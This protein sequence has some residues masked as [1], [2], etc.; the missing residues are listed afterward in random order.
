MSNDVV[1]GPDNGEIGS[2]RTDG[3]LNHPIRILVADDQAL[4][5]SGFA[6]MLRQYADLV[7]CG[8]ARDGAEAVLLAGTERP[9]VVLMDIRMPGIDGIAATRALMAG[10]DPPAIL[11][12][13]TYDIDEYVIEALRAGAAGY[14]LK[15]VEPAD[16]VAAV[17]SAASGDMPMAP[18]V[19]R[20][21]VDEFLTRT[22][23]STSPDESSPPTQVPAHPGLASLS[24]RER[25][26]TVL[27]AR[28][29]TNAEVAAELVVSTATVKTHVAA[30]LAKLGL[31]DRIQVVILAY[32]ARLIRPRDFGTNAD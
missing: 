23:P 16:L 28:G 8:Q 25:E 10:P 29:M 1:V 5:R 19:I 21:L 18:S 6:L 20:R 31:R 7:V 24:A 3:V 26:V 12:L 30:V 27:L 22:P 11:I 14:L 9:D 2:A 15:D 13:T 32:E 4:V 17:R